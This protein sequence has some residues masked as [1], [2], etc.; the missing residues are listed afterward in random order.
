MHAR[1]W[2][3][4]GDRVGARAGVGVED[5]LAQ[6][7]GAGVGR[8]GDGERRREASGLQHLDARCPPG[9]AST[10]GAARTVR[11]DYHDPIPGPARVRHDHRGWGGTGAAGDT[12]LIGTPI[13]G[14]REFY[15]NRQGRAGRGVGQGEVSVHVFAGRK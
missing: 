7:A 12:Q 1:S 10:V 13:A 4:E 5:G 9:P 15:H 14:P 3:V 11:S 2:D 8:V 6:R